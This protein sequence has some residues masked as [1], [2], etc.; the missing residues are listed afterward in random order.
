LPASKV[1]WP[2]RPDLGC[3]KRDA[4]AR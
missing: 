4:F 3:A 2:G 1:C